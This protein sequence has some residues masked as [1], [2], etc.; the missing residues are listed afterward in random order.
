M[1]KAPETMSQF[2]SIF[3]TPLFKAAFAL[4]ATGLSVSLIS[5]ATPSI[6]AGVFCFFYCFCWVVWLGCAVTQPANNGVRLFS[7]W[8]VIDVGILAMFMSVAAA[9]GDV[10]NAKGTDLV[11]LIT[12]VPV[13]VPSALISGALVHGLEALANAGTNGLN[14][15]FGSVLSA[16]LQMSA[17]GSIQSLLIFVMARQLHRW[18]QRAIGKSS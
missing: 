6:P 12:Y 16:W 7:L 8:V 11:W 2:S 15:T 13:I 14:P 17:I 9:N 3:G 18:R 5:F 4:A 10:M 1:Q